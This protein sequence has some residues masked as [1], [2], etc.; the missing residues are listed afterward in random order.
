MIVLFDNLATFLYTLDNI[1]KYRF[2][3]I[4]IITT[5]LE[6]LFESIFL[7]IHNFVFS[8]IAGVSFA[9]VSIGSLF[10]ALMGSNAGSYV[11]MLPFAACYAF[12]LAMGGMRSRELSLGAAMLSA[13][14]VLLLVTVLLL[15]SYYHSLHICTYQMAIS[16]VFS[17]LYWYVSTG[18]CW[19]VLALLAII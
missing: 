12:M 10:F 13:S 9:G 18:L 11:V 17:A 14:F 5:L 8:S 16:Y 15:V 19:V 7:L 2:L 4:F 3:S 6:P 1:M